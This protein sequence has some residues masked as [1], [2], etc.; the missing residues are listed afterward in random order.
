M[1][2]T[3]TSQAVADHSA[4]EPL[5]AAGT[6]RLI[7]DEFVRCVQEEGFAAASAK[8]VAERAGVTWGVIQYHFA[9]R[10][11]L[12]MAVVERGFDDLLDA[13]R[14]L[15]PRSLTTP[16]SAASLISAMWKAFN[17]ATSSAAMQILIS[18][19]TERGEEQSRYLL[20]VLSTLSHLGRFLGDGLAPRH[21]RVIGDLVWTSLL[22]SMTAQ[23]LGV[24]PV[25]TARER[26][27]LIDAVTAYIER[28]QQSGR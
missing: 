5:S 8:H 2:A 21:A 23:L 27:N 28:V 24:E 11:G 9:D 18:T 17:S 14:A 10:D 22:G 4:A 1:I 20:E 6:R 7:I 16:Q 13:L 26:R 3:M 19:R 12:L 25:N 15:Q